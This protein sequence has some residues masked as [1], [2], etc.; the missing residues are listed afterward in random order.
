[1]SHLS[2]EYA[3]PATATSGIASYSIDGAGRKRKTM[4]LRDLLLLRRPFVLKGALLSRLRKEFDPD[5]PRDEGG[6]WDSDGS[7]VSV[8]K[9]F[10]QTG[11]GNL[12]E[13]G[14]KPAKRGKGD[15]VT[16]A[17]RVAWHTAI[18]TGKP[19]TA[20]IT[21]RG[22]AV[23]RGGERVSYGTPHMVV[24]PSGDVFRFRS[25]LMSDHQK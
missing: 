17:A 2:K 15:S 8:P 3:Q 12:K 16:D 22:W 10:E 6:Q 11:K 18:T 7:G 1:M 5:Q 23:L 4:T 13:Q 21:T 25:T 20:Q 14:F 19:A 24:T 9:G